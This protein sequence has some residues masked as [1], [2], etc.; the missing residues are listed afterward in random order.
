MSRS[1]RTITELTVALATLTAISSDL[2]AQVSQGKSARAVRI[3]GSAPRID[4]VLDDAVWGSA[5]VIAD[6]VQKIPVEGAAPS[7][8]TEVR[9][10]FDDHGL[11]VG[12]R[13]RRS[14]GGGAA[15]RSS[16]ISRSR[17]VRWSPSTRA[18]CVRLPAAWSN[19]LSMRRRLKF[20]TAP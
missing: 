7:V 13:L 2:N 12:A 17:Y 16:R 3:T 8:V 11:Y 15:T 14:G 18:A 5:P 6:F 1:Q 20:D 9:L 4:G 19:A 10:L